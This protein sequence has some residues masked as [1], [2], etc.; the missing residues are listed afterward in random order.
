MAGAGAFVAACVPGATSATPKPSTDTSKLVIALDNLGAQNWRPWLTSSA[1]DSIRLIVGDPLIL[2]DPKTRDL[3][4]GLAE[5][6]T[7]SADRKT[8]NFKLRANVPFH[9]DWGTLTADD[10]KFTW[11]QYVFHPEQTHGFIAEV[12]KAAVGGSMNGFTVVSPLE[13]KV[14]TSG[15]PAHNLLNVLSVRETPMP[16]QS[17]R[18]WTEKP[19]DAIN[20]PIGTG[21]YRFLL[22]TP[23][24]EVQ[25]EAVDK[26]WRKT[27][28]FKNVSIKVIGDGASR[29]AQVQSGGVDLAVLTASLAVEAKKSGLNVFS[30][31]DVGSVSMV[32]GGNYPGIGDPA[33][34]ETAAV[35]NNPLG[36]TRY[37]RNAP[38]IQ[39]DSP[40]KGL[41]IRQALSFAIDRK[42]V[43]DKIL[44]GEGTLVTAPA[45]QYPSNPKLSDPSWKLPVY[46]VAQAK[47]KLT[48]GG[49][50]N[51][52]D[53]E[54]VLYE[55]RAGTGVD[56][57]A[58]AVAG[59][60]EAIG[61]K[62]KRRT[63]DQTT[64]RPNTMN[65]TTKGQ[66]WARLTPFFQDPAQ[67][68]GSTFVPTA[69][70]AMLY[71]PVITDAV[72]KMLVED[73]EDKVFAI[74]RTTL[75]YMRNALIPIPMFT[76]NQSWA[77]GKKI[78]SWSPLTAQSLLTFIE[79]IQPPS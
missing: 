22:S 2:A 19:N 67:A 79:T 59:M 51:G 23:G 65:R 56:L 47:A 76:A 26:H 74:T 6:W 13:F 27:P 16:I 14:T 36:A 31:K 46:D 29:L 40:A 61:I 43:L 50:P 54:M 10:V 71:D 49:Y 34:G 20:F 28:V 1:E 68:L 77:A 7:V 18:Y 48:E 4:P 52:F 32:L 75:D 5:S 25:L 24:V 15:T 73:D 8:Y 38:W 78:G 30:V 58:E 66:A 41:A 72:K 12:M 70:P 42:V 17:K 55:N 53:I 64:E 69:G 45:V 33:L 57:V 63:S 62:V 3:V 11:E 9:G 44:A 35:R 39:A 21:P 37:D 60:W